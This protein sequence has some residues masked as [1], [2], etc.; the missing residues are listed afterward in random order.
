[1]VENAAA[2]VAADTRATLKT[3]EVEPATLVNRQEAKMCA[4]SSVA[5]R[6]SRISTD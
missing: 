6:N 3:A 1:V 2:A 4:S 5:F